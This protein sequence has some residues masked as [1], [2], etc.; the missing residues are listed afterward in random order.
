MSPAIAATDDSAPR[1][2]RLS[3]AAREK[4]RDRHHQNLLKRAKEVIQGSREKLVQDAAA[5][6]EAGV[7]EV[8][9]FSDDPDVLSVQDLDPVKAQKPSLGFQANYK[10][11]A[12]AAGLT[13]P[14]LEQEAMAIKTPGE[15]MAAFKSGGAADAIK[16]ELEGIKEPAA[17]NADASLL[18]AQDALELVK[19]GKRLAQIEKAAREANAEVDRSPS[20]PK[21]FVL[22]TSDDVDADAQEDIA[23]DL[24]TMQTS[25]FLAE[26]G[27]IAGG[28]PEETLGGH[29]GVGAYN[30]INSLALA[31]GGDALVDRSVVDVLGVAGA[32]QVLARR[33]HADL[34]EDARHVADGV[35]DWHLNHYMKTS[36]EA[37]KKARDL[38]D[39]AK[40]IE[41]SDEAQTGA[42]LAVAQEL[43]ARRRA[44]VGDAQRILGQALGEMEANA[45]LV[46]AMK[47]PGSGDFQVSLG[48]VAPEQGFNSVHVRP[49]NL[50]ASMAFLCEGYE[51]GGRLSRTRRSED[52]HSVNI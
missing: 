48:A 44:A 29:I 42:E 36:T 16:A 15:L 47:A 35:Q 3:E 10:G 18:S 46:L 25:A 49:P 51:G 26:V 8:P 37:L 52:P 20:E 12:E 17:P 1:L 6:A 5:R 23:N 13:Q 4:V 34:G 33:L 22:E 38:M 27:R 2:A 45:A 14:A 41:V 31:A 28:K 21:A 43:N 32:A 24:R 11:R 39:A 50:C 7:G 40:A 19:E 30:S 9:L